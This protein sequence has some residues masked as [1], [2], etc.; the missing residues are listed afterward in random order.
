[1][2]TTR[3]Y[4]KEK[5]EAIKDIKD[6]SEK[7][8]ITILTDHQ[9]MSVAQMTIL[10]NRLFDVKAQYKVVKNTLSVR[11][12]KK[13][14]AELVKDLFNGPTSII[15]GYDD[16]VAPAKILA[17]FI[18]E[19]EKPA[20]KGALMDGKFIGVPEIKKLAALNIIGL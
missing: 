20:I 5:T 12:I 3:V 2:T 19:N 8:A 14:E 9:G 1:M 18:K 6:W 11:A 7:S 15:F 4:K 16:V 13:E 17:A 10:R